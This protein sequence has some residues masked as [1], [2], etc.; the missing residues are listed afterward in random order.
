MKKKDAEIKMYRGIVWRS[1]S[2]LSKKLGRNVTYVS[3]LLLRHPEMSE[4]DVIDRHFGKAHGGLT[5]KT[6]VDLSIK[7]GKC[8]SYVHATLKQHKGMTEED[9]ID[10]TK[11]K[12]YRGI[13]WRNR[14]DLQLQ[15]GGDCYL[16]L[17]NNQ[18]KPSKIILTIESVK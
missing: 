15:I 7:L 16:Y 6:H 1:R 12:S 10:M 2:E 8:P 18:I 11:S 4:Q 13:V 5:W 3:A 14:H 17:K 9:L